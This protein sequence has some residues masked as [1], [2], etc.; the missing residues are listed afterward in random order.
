MSANKWLTTKIR[1]III[2]NKSFP[3]D[4][5]ESG[6]LK[7]LEWDS[8][9][10]NQGTVR[11]AIKAWVRT[12][13]KNVYNNFWT[14]LYI[15]F[16]MPELK[17][18]IAC[19]LIKSAPNCRSQVPNLSLLIPSHANEWQN[20]ICDLNICMIAHIHLKIYI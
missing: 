9:S 12:S 19:S 20:N 15:I 13:N 18:D 11:M 17:Q 14:Y 4:M 5:L 8:A 16:R 6:I 7:K 1:Q 3:M 2:H 10:K